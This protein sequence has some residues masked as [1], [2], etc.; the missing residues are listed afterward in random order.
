M[1][2]R[3][4]NGVNDRWR[5]DSGLICI[6]SQWG[7]DSFQNMS[8]RTE[9]VK[10][11][12]DAQ[13]KVW[14]RSEFSLRLQDWL[15]IYERRVHNSRAS[16]WSIQRMTWR[17]RCYQNALVWKFQKQGSE[18]LKEKTTDGKSPQQPSFTS[19]N[20]QLPCSIQIPIGHPRYL[21]VRWQ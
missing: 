17:L 16:C 3:Q 8:A 10:E 13:I 14:S 9:A 20:Q 7:L 6:H 11:I 12:D 2:C 4:K 1:E 19:H 18:P 21:Q 15:R 5:K